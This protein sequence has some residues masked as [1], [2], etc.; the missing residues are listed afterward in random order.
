MGSIAYSSHIN[1]EKERTQTNFKAFSLQNVPI[2]TLHHYS[3]TTLKGLWKGFDSTLLKRPEVDSSAI[4]LMIRSVNALNHD[5]VRPNDKYGGQM[6]AFSFVLK[7]NTNCV[8]YDCHDPALSY[9]SSTSSS[10]R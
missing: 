9:N 7:K 5:I 3:Y 8:E 1:D 10:I 4:E 2:N 6:Y